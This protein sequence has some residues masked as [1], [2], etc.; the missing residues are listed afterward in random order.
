MTVRRALWRVYDVA[1]QPSSWVLVLSLVVAGAVIPMGASAA[2][3]ATVD[4]FLG[5]PWALPLLSGVAIVGGYV[6]Q[7][8]S[9]LRLIDRMSDRINQLELR[10]DGHAALPG[11]PVT[12]AQLAHLEAAQCEQTSLLRGVHAQLGELANALARLEGKTERRA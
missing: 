6:A 3:E 4:G 10:V 2:S 11:H 9:T 8:R 7:T 1:S 12:V 5:A